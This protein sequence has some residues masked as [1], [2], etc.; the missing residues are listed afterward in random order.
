[1]S[2][3]I[4]DISGDIGIKAYGKTCE[5]AFINAGIGMFS[6]ITDIDRIADSK[7][8]EFEI[9]NDLPEG[10]LVNYL[11]EMIFHFDT[12]GFIGRRIL[13]DA[14]SFQPSAH[15]AARVYGEEF[16]AGRHE[17]RLLV[18]A[19]TYHNVKVEKTGDECRVEVI[20]D[21]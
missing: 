1:M 17:R 7:S 4:L 16:D 14:F 10:L 8:I 20:F 3:E 5:E 19:A 9:E 12:Y 15:I 2:Y 13:M 21:I 11:N 18:K 6:L